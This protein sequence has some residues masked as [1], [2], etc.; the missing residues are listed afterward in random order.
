MEIIKRHVMRKN[1]LKDLKEELRAVVGE[2]VETI[3]DKNIEVIITESGELYAKNKEILAFKYQEKILPS[4][5]AINNGL[6][7]LP[8]VTV[9][10]GA[11]P[12]VTNGA[13]VMAP[14]ITKLDPG[15]KKDDYVMVVD[16]R[17]GKALAICYLLFDVEE[18]KKMTKGKALKTIHYVNDILWNLTL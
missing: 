2:S 14:G 11:V 12:Y 10:M 13:D 8:S 18:I 1:D 4:L 7:K 6:M 17:F 15:L 16:E 9:D 5:R 3:I